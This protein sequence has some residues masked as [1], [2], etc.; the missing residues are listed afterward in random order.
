MATQT[1]NPLSN[2][3]YNTLESSGTGAPGDPNAW[4]LE[5]DG[6]DLTLV[7][8]DDTYIPAIDAGD[9]SFPVSGF[10]SGGGAI[11]NVRVYHRHKE[12][13]AATKHGTSYG[14]IV[15]GGTRYPGTVVF[16]AVWTLSYDDFAKNPATGL[17]WTDADIN[18]AEYG[19]HGAVAA[20]Q[21]GLNSYI[22]ET[23]MV[24]T[25]T[26]SVSVTYGIQLTTTTIRKIFSTQKPIT[27]LVQTFAANSVDVLISRNIA[28]FISEGE[29]TPEGGIVCTA[30]IE[31]ILEYH[32]FTGDL[33]A[34]N[35]VSGT[36]NLNI[37][38]C[39]TG[40]EIWVMK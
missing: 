35:A 19:F 8:T 20:T 38:I 30:N 9:F 34:K 25:Y 28:D 22:S 23:Y 36:T 27:F 24:V 4:K 31:R 17:T 21:K 12:D 15:V 1:F 5:S 3:T 14:E 33:Y 16:T 29:S 13:V 10:S 7:M 39:K 32:D 37:I 26:V 18:S 6:S 2:G 40:K 11:T